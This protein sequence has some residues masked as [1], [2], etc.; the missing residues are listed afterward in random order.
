[1]LTEGRRNAVGRKPASQKPAQPLSPGVL[2]PLLC[3]SLGLGFRICEVGGW[4]GNRVRVRVRVGL[5][6]LEVCLRAMFLG[7]AAD[8]L[9]SWPLKFS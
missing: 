1:M 4:S 8:L 6:G 3:F 9:V 7:A 2:E 5:C